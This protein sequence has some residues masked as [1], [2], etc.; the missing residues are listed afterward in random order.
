[1]TAD[2]L[3]CWHHS[4][5]TAVL[6]EEIARSCRAFEN[7]AFAGGIMHDLWRLGLLVAYPQEYRHLIRD[8]EE[9]GLDLLELEEQ[10]LGMSHAEAGRLLTE[11]WGLPEEFRVVNGRH[12]D[13]CDGTEIDLL[14]IVHVACRLADTLGFA[15]VSPRLGLAAGELAMPPGT[16]WKKSP[17]ELCG[18][19]EER[20]SAVT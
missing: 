10:K 2:M 13:S 8:A 14:W 11:S 6:A 3:R 7:I 16:S 4:I 1:M 19:I 5:A 17:D 9:N 20:I 18:L 15:V 12:H